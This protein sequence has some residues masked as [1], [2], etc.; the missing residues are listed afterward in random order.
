MRPLPVILATG[1]P[2]FR[3]TDFMLPINEHRPARLCLLAKVQFFIQDWYLLPHSQWCCR[4]RSRFAAK[5]GAAMASICAYV[6]KSHCR[7]DL[8]VP[9]AG[10]SVGATC[11]FE[12]YDDDYA[13]TMSASGLI[14]GIQTAKTY[15]HVLCQC[16]TDISYKFK[17]DT[18]CPLREKNPVKVTISAPGPYAAFVMLC[19]VVWPVYSA[20]T[21]GLREI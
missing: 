12:C 6:H 3:P 21:A 15:I 10:Q 2:R 16:A 11:K 1:A 7:A 13:L 18:P 14:W 5:P 19:V 20:W 4:T 17:T 9:E 8:A